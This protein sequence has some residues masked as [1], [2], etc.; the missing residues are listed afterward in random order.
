M[1]AATTVPWKDRNPKDPKSPSKNHRTAGER[2]EQ[3]SSFCHSRNGNIDQ[4]ASSQTVQGPDR[5]RAEVDETSCSSPAPSSHSS[6]RKFLVSFAPGDPE[7]PY[8]WSSGRKVFIVLVGIATVVNSTLGSALPSGATR[9]IAKYFHITSEEELVLPISIYLVGYI[10]GPILCGPLSET[11]GRKV[12]MLTTFGFFTAFT[13]GC[14]LAPNWPALLIFRFL[15]GISASSP[16]SVVGGLMADV[17]NDPVTRGRA[18]ALFMAATTFGPLIGP[19][20]SGFVSVV[21][22]RWTFWVE[23]MIAGATWPLCLSLPETCGPI[24]LKRRAENLRKQRSEPRIYAPMDLERKGAKETI[25]IVLSRPIR[26]FFTEAIVLFTCLYM[27]LAYAIFY[28]FFQAYPIIFQGIYG[29]STGI[30]GLAFIPIGVGALIACAMFLYWDTILQRAKERHAPWAAAEEN[31]RLPLAC[32]GG[33]LY[34]LS[35][36]WLGWAA[37]P[38]IHW[39]VPMMAGLPF[40]VG[41]LLIF[42][43]LLN[44]LTDAY[45]IYAASA[46]AAA[47]C[48]R[49]I[50]GAALPFAGTKMYNK[51]GVHWASSLLGFLSLGMTLIPFVFI[52]YGDRIRANSALSN[53]LS[54]LKTKRD[55]EEKEREF[56][57]NT[58]DMA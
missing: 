3:S 37:N 58:V 57:D 27:S 50:W 21:S 23:L 30:L 19:I 12:V 24:I 52:K 29:M 26:M 15:V 43:A 33:P 11:Y 14:A 6:E 41:F 56:G 32:V 49:S 48:S 45:D 20:I 42:M 25:T 51:L 5:P 4:H 44:Y 1:T 55:N 36:F 53:E 39:I 17:Y 2:P 35:L 9:Y 28:L 40:G 8:N 18:M 22:W 38:T 10:V 31:R 13:L 7:N 34:V 54:E 47:S 46:M 16:I